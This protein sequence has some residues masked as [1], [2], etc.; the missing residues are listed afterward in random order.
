MSN[1]ESWSLNAQTT[2]VDLARGRFPHILLPIFQ[3]LVRIKV[4]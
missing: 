3:S 4:S 1:R 2:F